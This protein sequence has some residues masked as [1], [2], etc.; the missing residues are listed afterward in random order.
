M[1]DWA[2]QLA[3]NKT[4]FFRGWVQRPEF[5]SR[6]PFGMS[7]LDFVNALNAAGGFPLTPPERDALVA[8]LSQN[9]TTQGRA[10][11]VRQMA[12]MHGGTVHA[13]SDGPGQGATFRILLPVAS[14][15]G[16]SAD[17]DAKP[18]LPAASVDAAQ[19]APADADPPPRLPRET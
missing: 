13:H 2:P 7:P 12:E 15:D 1:G 16:A 8:Q 6:Y 10:A 14:K 11:I 18:L 9:N 4:A 19:A 5:L 3:A 17:G